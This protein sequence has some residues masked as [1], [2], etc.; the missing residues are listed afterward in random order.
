MEKDSVI[1]FPYTPSV[2]RKM[3]MFYKSLNEKN[4]RHYAALE[5]DRLGY[6]GVTYIAD[7]L[8]CDRSTVQAGLEEFKKMIYYQHFK[9]VDMVTAE[10]T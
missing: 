3:K 7:L 4:Q 1:A 10:S 9:F 8:G 2:E 6:G 5:A